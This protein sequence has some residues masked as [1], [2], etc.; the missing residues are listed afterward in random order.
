ARVGFELVDGSAILQAVQ[1]N[2]TASD[3]DALSVSMADDT[4]TKLGFRTDG[5]HIRYYINDSLVHSLAIDS[6]IA[7]VTLGPAF[8]GL[9]GND[10]GTHTRSMDYVFA[11]QER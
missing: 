10:T 4:W 5:G 9:S 1:D 6:A 8:F 3:K 2:D 11:V 7:A